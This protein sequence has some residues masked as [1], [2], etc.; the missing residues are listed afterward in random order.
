[1]NKKQILIITTVA[2]LTALMLMSGCRSKQR[3]GMVREQKTGLLYGSMTNGNLMADPS[4]FDTPVLKL[5]I[6]N[7]S[8][9]PA[10]NLKAL[11][12]TFADAYEDKGYKVVKTG[13][14]SLH[15]DINLR[16]SGQISQNMVDE[17]SLWGGTGGAYMGAS[18]GQN[19]D[20]LV[21]GSASGAALGAIIGQYMT[22]DTY[23]MVADVML[24]I[25]DKY[26]RK[27]KAIVQFG[28]TQIK[29]EDEEDGFTA[30]RSRDRIKV[31]VYAG[32]DNTPQ[33][34]IVRGVTLRFKRILQDII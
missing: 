21:L 16:Y 31:A 18:L 27:R 12:K 22:Q 23:I 11:R 24:G 26:A 7:T 10:I 1:M 34:K 3:M 29:W 15:L 17:I 9:D 14:Y 6:R 5:T 25:V 2:I 28:D 4:Q 20:S 30:Y 19:L 8:G 32:G 33:S 13:Q